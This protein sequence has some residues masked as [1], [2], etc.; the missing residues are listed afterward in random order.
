MVYAFEPDRLM[1]EDFS[2]VIAGA[3][4]IRIAENNQRAR[5]GTVDEPYSCLQNH[6]ARTFAAH[7]SASDVKTFFRKQFIEVVPRN[8]A[9]NPGISAADLIRILVA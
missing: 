3:V 1:L 4:N 9:R 5:G 8:T 7:Q 6:D 2:D